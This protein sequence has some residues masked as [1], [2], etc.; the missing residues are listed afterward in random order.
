[1]RVPSFD[2]RA[3]NEPLAAEIQAA[4]AR[5]I[6]SGRYIGGEEVARF[7]AALAEAAGTRSA[8]A[9]S[10]GTDALLAALLALRVGPGDA[11]ITTPFSYFATVGSIVRTGARPVF[12]DID[13]RTFDLDPAAVEAAIARARALPG[14]VRVAAVV[15]VHLFGRM[16]PMEQLLAIARRHGLAV[17]ED[18][19]QSFGARSGGRAAGALGD[20][21]CYSFYPTKNLGGLGDGGA[22]VTDDAELAARIRT[23]RQHGQPEG[24]GAYVHVEV[25]GN[26]RLDAMQCAALAVKLPHVERWNGQR[27]ALAASYAAAFAA[28]GLGERVVP[29][30]S[31]APGEHCWHQYVVRVRDRDRLRAHL[32]ERGIGSAVYYPVPLHLQPCLREHAGRRGDCPQAERAAEEVLALP[33]WPGLTEEA[34]GEVVEAIGSF[35][36][37]RVAHG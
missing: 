28:A 10:S 17:V 29:P 18:A 37:A 4:V 3:Q 34:V 26:F 15:V 35:A 14:I 1:M 16:A 25:G 6:A 11:V 31:G 13:P 8:V 24:G 27:R 2:A 32:S 5:V 9:L 30:E 36:S 19:A 22:A 7:E 33:I 20:V 23:L 21:G 12:A